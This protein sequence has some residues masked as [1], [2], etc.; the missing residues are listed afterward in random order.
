MYIDMQ[1]GN[2]MTSYRQHVQESVA[3]EGHHQE[4]T[5]SRGKNLFFFGCI[6]TFLF[7]IMVGCMT[8]TRPNKEHPLVHRCCALGWRHAESMNRKTSLAAAVYTLSQKFVDGFE[9]LKKGRPP[10]S[11]SQPSPSFV[12]SVRCNCPS[13]RGSS[14]PDKSIFLRQP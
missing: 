4:Q 5:D 13:S 9:V 7:L 6:L 8:L 1:S 3:A 11:R 12:P 14:G 10:R 2:C